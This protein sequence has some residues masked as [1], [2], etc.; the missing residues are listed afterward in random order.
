MTTTKPKRPGQTIV[1]GH[2]DAELQKRVRLVARAL[3]MS[4]SEFVGV[5]VAAGVGAIDAAVRDDN[6][7]TKEEEGDDP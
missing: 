3:G 6:T 4:V 5:T 2:V 7:T 1:S